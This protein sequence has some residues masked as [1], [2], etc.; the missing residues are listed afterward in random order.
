MTPR[1]SRFAVDALARHAEVVPG[2]AFKSDRFTDDP[3][4]VALIKGENVQQG[5][6]D[7]QSSRHWPAADADTSLKKFELRPGDVV[8]AMDR[9]WVA[10]GLKWAF[11]K[12]HDPRALLVQRVARLRAR[13]GLDQTYLRC[14][15]SSRR[16]SEYI[17]PIVTGVN[18]PHISARQI[19]EFDLPVPPLPVQRKIAAVI[20]AYDALIDTHNRRITLLERIAEE[21]YR[22]WFIRLRF[23]GHARTSRVKGVPAG[24]THD[25]AARCFGLVKGKSYAGDELTDDPTHMPFISLKSFHRGGGYRADGLKFYA[26]RHRD[27]QVVRRGDVVVALTDMT[28]DRAIV[29]RPARI[30]DLGPRGAVLSLDAAR[31]VPHAVDSTFLYAHVRYSGFADGLRELANGANVVHLQPGL[32]TRQPILLPPRALQDAYA[33]K[34][35]PMYTQMDLLAAAVGLLAATRERLLTRLV[36]GELALDE[37]EIRFPPEM[38]TRDDRGPRASPTVTA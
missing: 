17:Q 7:W 16:F 28:Q 21:L 2:H 13:D 30:P 32:I 14:V 19:G 36:S 10:A 1:I 33:S 4:D 29:G 31:L 26:G 27:E 6:I 35:A 20:A 15:I 3:T 37:L 34:V 24:W 38:M 18:V 8:L 11:I 5:F 9:P 22:E 25:S 12:K 23:P